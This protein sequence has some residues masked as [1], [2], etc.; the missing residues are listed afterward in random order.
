MISVLFDLLLITDLTVSPSFGLYNGN[1]PATVLSKHL[2]FVYPALHISPK[3]HPYFYHTYIVWDWY[4]HCV[5]KK[6][7]DHIFDDKLK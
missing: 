5:P 1:D 6:T 4:I 2:F 7:C 3:L